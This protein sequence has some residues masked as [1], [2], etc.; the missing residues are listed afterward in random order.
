MPVKIRLQR[1]GRK[2]RPFYH[3]VAADAR[4]PRDGKFIEKLGIY[5]PMTKPATIELDREKAYEWLTK[6]AQPTD[7]VRAILRFK[8]VMYRKHLMRGVKKGAL[9]QEAADQK[10][11]E[12]VDNKEAN[13]AARR[14]EAA[15][16]IAGL[17]AKRF[18]DVP[19][20]EKVVEEQ[21]AV[22]QDIDETLAEAAERK[23]AEE[24]AATEEA[25][26]EEAAPA[27]EEVAKEAAP[28]EEAQ[29]D[30]LTKIEG[31]GPKISETIQA[32][33]I[34]T[35]AQLAEATPE[36]IKEILDKAEGNFA[37]HDPK[38]WPAQAKMAADGEWDKLKAWQDELDG[39][40]EVK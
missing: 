21:A 12:W 2:K 10:W 14:E 25:P 40:K 17:H 16:E 28:A 20:V 22:A 4:A 24:A 1:R 38:T 31:I 35:F 11:Q 8:G 36:S 26:V 32:G 7:T 30:D 34:K 37:A 33:G 23:A 29:A 39:G 15:T 3:I 13:V 9:T 19:V 27:A 18:G 6:G 5:N